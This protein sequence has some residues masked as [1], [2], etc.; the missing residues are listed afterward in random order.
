[1]Y[2]YQLNIAKTFNIL[3]LYN[4]MQNNDTDLFSLIQEI[5]FVL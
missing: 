1:M 4:K 5:V 3:N 2:I